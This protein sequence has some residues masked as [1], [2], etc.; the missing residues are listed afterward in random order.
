MDLA[1]VIRI[2]FADAGVWSLPLVGHE[3]GHFVAEEFRVRRRDRS[4]RYLFQE[5]VRSES[6]IAPSEA[7]HLHERFADLFAVY[8][9]GPAAAYAS[10]LLRFDPSRAGEPT[11]HHPSDAERVH[12]MLRALTL[13]DGE[14]RGAPEYSRAIEQLGCTWAEGV[15]A[16]GT[17]EELTQERIDALEPL[18]AT[19]YG[20]LQDKLPPRLRYDGWLRALRLADTLG[21]DGQADPSPG[22]ACTLPDVLNAAWICRANRNES[23]A[24]E[25]YRIGE[26]ALRLCETLCRS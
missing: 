4:Y 26:K 23:D 11:A 6:R 8:A 16:A 25:V 22:A 2:R 12:G 14:R 17:S 5:F 18:L 7:Q 15:R 19:M 9:L 3:F 10:V 1:A 20:W 13:M 24:V 21:A